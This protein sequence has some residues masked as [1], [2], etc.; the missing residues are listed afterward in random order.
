MVRVCAEA[1]KFANNTWI[2]LSGGTWIIR[3]LDGP[4]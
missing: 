1:T 2:S 4:H 3:D